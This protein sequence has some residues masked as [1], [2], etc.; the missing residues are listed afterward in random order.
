[1]RKGVPIAQ[2]ARDLARAIN[3]SIPYTSFWE[4]AIKLQVEANEPKKKCVLKRRLQSKVNAIGPILEVLE[5]GRE[6]DLLLFVIV[7][8]YSRYTFARFATS[9][10]EDS[11]Q[12]ERVCRFR[13]C[14]S[15]SRVR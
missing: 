1:L 9:M 6:H 3:E 10:E 13:R 4:F 7:L 8:G 15:G 11:L 14:T 5:D 12:R 2:I